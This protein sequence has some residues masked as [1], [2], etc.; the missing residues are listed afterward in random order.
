[1][2]RESYEP[3]LR[4]ALA[5]LEGAL[6]VPLV[7]G[8]LASWVPP[9]QQGLTAVG[10]YLRRQI[11]RVHKEEMKTIQQEDLGLARRVEQ[12]AEEDQQII[13]QFEQLS[14]LAQKLGAAAV[15]I[16]PDEAAIEPEQSRLV[17]EGL[18]FVIR[19]RKQEAAIATWLVEAFDR[20]R[21]DVD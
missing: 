5:Q 17:D 9:V 10:T 2:A 21:G 14:R 4:E 7:P 1:M 3:Q 12:M 16:E 15:A 13:Q 20:D 19:V 8:E 11:E 6:E 18:E